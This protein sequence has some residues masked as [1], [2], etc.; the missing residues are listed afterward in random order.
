M[1]QACRMDQLYD[2]TESRGTLNGSSNLENKLCAQTFAPFKRAKET[3][4]LVIPNLFDKRK[5]LFFDHFNHVQC[6]LTIC[7]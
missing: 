4:Y 6:I 1:E 2:R 7:K 5:N 3:R